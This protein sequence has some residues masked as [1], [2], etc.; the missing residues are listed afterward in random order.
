M[1]AAA[2]KATK[3]KAAARKATKVKAAGMKAA[4]MKATKGEKVSKASAMKAKAMKATK[5]TKVSKA[6]AMKSVAM[7]ATKGKAAAMKAALTMPRT[8][9][10][11]KSW[12]TTWRGKFYDWRLQS[13]ENYGELV[14]EKWAGK[15][16]PAA[17]RGGRLRRR[18]EEGWL[19]G[20]LHFDARRSD[21]ATLWPVVFSISA[22]ANTLWSF[23]LGLPRQHVP[24]RAIRLCE[25]PRG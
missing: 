20:E 14:E 1:K 15:L 24:R 7:K 16:L 19:P 12:S 22:G 4:A 9:I 11:K 10:L 23:R 18:C 17:E 3:V 21:D 6:A 8:R 13:I 25:F 5:A 2:M